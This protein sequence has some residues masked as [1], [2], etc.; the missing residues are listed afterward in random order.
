MRRLG[1]RLRGLLHDRRRDERGAAA[2]LMGIGLTLVLVAIAAFSVDLGMQRATRRDM[3]ALADLVALDLAR[4][5]DG[6]TVSGLAATMNTEMARSVARNGDTLGDAPELDWDLGRM[7]G[8]DFVEL[9]D[10]DVPSAVRVSAGTS[11]DFQ[12]GGVTGVTQ[13]DAARTAIA[14]RAVPSVCF[15]VGAKTLTLNTAESA[16]GPLLNGILQ[17]NL[18]A[19]GYEG[20]VDVKNV[21]VPLVDLLVELNVGSIDQVATTNVSLLNLML[22]T[23]DV[24]R[25]EGNTAAAQILEGITLTVPGLDIPLGDILDVGTATDLSGLDVDLNVLDI[26]GAG[27]VAANGENAI[28]VSVP[29][30]TEIT[31]IE[32]P[33]TGCGARGATAESGQIRLRLAPSLLSAALP[34]LLESTVDL[35]VIV[36]AATATIDA[37]LECLPD[38]VTMRTRTAAV[39]VLP[40]VPPSQGQVELGVTMSKFLNSIPALGPV[41]S[42]ALNLL[43]LNRVDLDVALRGGVSV[44]EERRRI[45]YPEPPELPPVVTFPETGVAQALTVQVDHVKLGLG[46]QGL[47]S[48]LNPVLA[49][50]LSGVVVPIANPVVALLN[51]ALTPIF[52]TLTSVLGLKLGVADVRMHGRPVCAGVKL[53]G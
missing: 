26:I 35:S 32:P 52:N 23:A 21:S 1:G 8:S 43:G 40:P 38:V 53:V 10:D 16:L 2:V 50:V 6:R 48:V 18:G 47:L 24:L 19:I 27:I 44:T 4:Q 29:G 13:G 12:F 14:R 15:S 51:T 42:L 33:K 46:Q 37:D 22:A 30:V 17:A 25:A 7:D 41:L 5:L 49:S 31:I 45:L 11:V 3:Q 36:G 9:S 28:A 34:W 39:D 20:L